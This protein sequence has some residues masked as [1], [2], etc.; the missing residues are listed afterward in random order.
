MGVY[1]KISK[2]GRIEKSSQGK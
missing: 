2:G 1:L